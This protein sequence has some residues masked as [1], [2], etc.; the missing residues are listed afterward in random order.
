MLEHQA[1]AVLRALELLARDRG[2]SR[3]TQGIWEIGQ[4]LMDVRRATCQQPGELIGPAFVAQL[5]DTCAWAHE[6]I[7]AIGRTP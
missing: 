1:D 4:R 5:T 2:S 6:R 3:P 7:T